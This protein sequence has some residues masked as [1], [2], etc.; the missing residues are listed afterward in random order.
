MSKGWKIAAGVFAGV[1]VIAVLADK[2]KD[3]GSTT[4]SQATATTPL[5]QRSPS[6]RD[7]LQALMPADEAGVVAAVVAARNQYA[8]APNDMAKGASR[9][10]RARAVC[11]ALSSRSVSGWVG[12]VTDLTTNGEGKGVLKVEIGPDVSVKQC[13]FRHRR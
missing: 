13:L 8:S 2:G 10:A 3:A 1:V 4:Q 6:A 12:R 11:A 5:A 7:R 9:P